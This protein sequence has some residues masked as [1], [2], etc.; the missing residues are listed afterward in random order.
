MSYPRILTEAISIGLTAN[1]ISER[2][3]VVRATGFAFILVLSIE[4][5][6]M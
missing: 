4:T 3:V 6:V 1:L 2:M 5:L